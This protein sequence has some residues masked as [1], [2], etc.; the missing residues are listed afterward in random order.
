MRQWIARLFAIRSRDRLAPPAWGDTIVLN[1][2]FTFPDGVT[3]FQGSHP[4]FIL[5]HASEGQFQGMGTVALDFAN[6]PD[7]PTH[8]EGH[9]RLTGTIPELGIIEEDA[10]LV[11]GRIT[12][13]EP[14]GGN[15]RLILD[16]LADPAL[17]FAPDSI[18]VWDT[19]LP[20]QASVPLPATGLL[21]GLGVVI[22]SARKVALLFVVDLR[23]HS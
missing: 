14:F 12:Q 15:I 13:L 20:F 4:R 21:F 7:P 10:L 19:E 16:A 23:R 3:Y 5:G 1:D 11:S 9:F 17:G 6:M 18:F 22:L 2:F 8:D